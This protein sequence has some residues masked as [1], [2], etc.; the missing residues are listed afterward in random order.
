MPHATEPPNPEGNSAPRNSDDAPPVDLFPSLL[1][2]VENGAALLRTVCTR[3]HP[4]T[5][6][7]H[8]YVT[9]VELPFNEYGILWNE[10]NPPEAGEMVWQR[11]QVISM[12]LPRC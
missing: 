2:L 7:R 4:G 5:S 12:T 3:A 1:G 11:G 6:E 8:T 9:A 10:E